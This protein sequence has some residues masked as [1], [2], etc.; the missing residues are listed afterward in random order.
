MSEQ[1][2]PCPFCGS[3]RVMRWK[4]NIW[5]TVYCDNCSAAITKADSI[6]A[7]NR[8]VEPEPKTCEWTPSDSIYGAAYH[9]QCGHLWI[10]DNYDQT[11]EGR[12]MVYCPFC[13]GKI[14]VIEANGEER[15]EQ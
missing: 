3:E 7:W 1:L 6:T 10:A 12:D 15:D 9:A 5:E 8:R 14:V 2:K 13:G 11:P 4:G